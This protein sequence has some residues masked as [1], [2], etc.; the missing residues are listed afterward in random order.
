MVG[1]SVIGDCV[2][3]SPSLLLTI[4]HWLIGFRG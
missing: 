2:V 3:C 4:G 1:W